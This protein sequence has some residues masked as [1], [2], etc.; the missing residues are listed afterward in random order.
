M[1]ADTP[2]SIPCTTFSILF[3]RFKGNITMMAEGAAVLSSLKPGD[4]VLIAEACTHHALEDDIG[5]VKIPRWIRQ[6]TG[7]DVG[8]DHCAGKDYPENLVQ[9]RL[10]IHCGACT[11][12][13][14]EMLWR[15]EQA[16]LAGVAVT[17][18][19]M[20]ISVLQGVIERTLSP[21]PAA[22]DA[23]QAALAASTAANAVSAASIPTREI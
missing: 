19:G 10:V 17:N 2:P 21:F 15:I 3:S 18:Y 4:R 8:I 11:L 16:R 14:R 20:A 5:R 6:Y 23:Y 7:T 12:T 13:R 1:V 22:L 9:Y